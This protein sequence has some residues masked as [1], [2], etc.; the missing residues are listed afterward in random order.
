MLQ[1]VQAFD[2]APIEER[3]SDD[4]VA[5]EAELQAAD[6]MILLRRGRTCSTH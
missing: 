4:A 5:H 2:R 3:A 6:K 1:V